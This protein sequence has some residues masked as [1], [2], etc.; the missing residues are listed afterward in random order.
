MQKNNKKILK[1]IFKNKKVLITGHTG[2]KGS[3]LTLC[4]KY[5]GANVLGV[6]KNIPTSPS[7]FITSKINKVIK[8]KFLD[9]KDIDNIKNIINKFKP[10]FIFHLAAQSLVGTSYEKPL[11]TWNSNLMGTVNILETLKEF[12][13]RVTVVII[14]S[15]KSYKNVEKKSGYKETDLLG[16][17]DPYSA[18]KSAAEIAINSYYN[19]FLKKKKNIKLGI[20]RA[21]NVIGGGDWSKNRIIPDCVRSWSKKKRAQIRNPN[22]TRPWQHVLEAVWGY[23]FFALKLKLNN[24]LNGQAFNFGP[25]SKKNYKV[26]EL[27]KVMKK[28]WSDVYYLHPRKRKKFNESQL[29]KL[30]CAKAKKLLK[31][32]SVLNFN[33]IA[34]L[35]ADWYYSYYFKNKSTQSISMDQIKNFEKI[36]NQRN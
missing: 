25:K 30:N 22:S 15:D 33:E 19:S 32:Q 7:N 8:S 35:T 16:G 23:I 14:T 17:D 5:L 10:D 6:S 28:H 34:K 4:L 11:V 2:F 21:G 18:S 1:K 26:S 31:W 13:K 27:L 29:L 24:K 9:I 12:K 3:W 36:F 20:A